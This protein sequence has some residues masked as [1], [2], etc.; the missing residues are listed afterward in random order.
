MLCGQLHTHLSE[1]VADRKG[2]LL[3]LLEMGVSFGAAI[4]HVHGFRPAG[5]LDW[6]ENLG[7]QAILHDHVLVIYEPASVEG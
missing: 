3:A 1:C 6:V 4:L 7:E 5:T 2:K